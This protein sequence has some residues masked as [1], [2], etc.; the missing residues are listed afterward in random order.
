MPIV[1]LAV[2]VG[3][4][5]VLFGWSYALHR[6][7]GRPLW[8][9]LW[10]AFTLTALALLHGAAGL[11][12]YVV[13]RRNPFIERPPVWV[14]HVVWTEV[15]WAGAALLVSV[16]FWRIGLRRLSRPVANPGKSG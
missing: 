9:P 2:I 14:G 12:G 3:V 10:I 8:N 16:V 6:R 4:V 15:A 5:A 1:T 11:M 13:P 7:T